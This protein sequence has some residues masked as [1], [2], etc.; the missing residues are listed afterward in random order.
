MSSKWTKTCSH[1]VLEAI[2]NK[3]REY[4]ANNINK[5]LTEDV[6]YVI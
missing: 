2:L 4:V 3:L 6:D 1:S 5:I